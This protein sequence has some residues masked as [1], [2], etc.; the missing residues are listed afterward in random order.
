MDAY[1]S[2]KLQKVLNIKIPLLLIAESW[3]I[4]ASFLSTLF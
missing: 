2:Q 4:T 3:D 1:K